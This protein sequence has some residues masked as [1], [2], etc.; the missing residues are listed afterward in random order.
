MLTTCVPG[1]IQAASKR[2]PREGVAV[3]TI[4]AAHG[5]LGRYGTRDLTAVV[6]PVDELGAARRGAAYDQHGADRADA[7]Q[8]RH[9]EACLIAGAEYGQGHGLPAGK[10]V[11]GDRIGR[12]G[13]VC[14]DL[15][16][17]IT[18]RSRPDS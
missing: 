12:G 1:P 4:S 15:S 17:S 16:A 10:Q 6:D 18:A 9:F 8:R 3:T 7:R 2:G 13:P 11:G 14:I 5:L